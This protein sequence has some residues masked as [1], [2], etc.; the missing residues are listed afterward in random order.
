MPTHSQQTRM[1]GAP[2]GLGVCDG[3]HWLIVMSA[4]NVAVRAPTHSQSRECV[5]HPALHLSTPSVLLP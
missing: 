2:G 4:L 1:Y 3:A 5:G